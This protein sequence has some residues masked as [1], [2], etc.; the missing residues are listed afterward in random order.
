M[1]PLWALGLFTVARI[2]D[3][4]IKQLRFRDNFVINVSSRA[5][6]LWSWL[7]VLHVF[8]DIRERLKSNAF[9]GRSIPQIHKKGLR[10]LH[11][12]HK[13]IYYWK[14]CN[15]GDKVESGVTRVVVKDWSSALRL[16]GTRH[17]ENV[18]FSK[19]AMLVNFL[20]STSS[21]VIIT[22]EKNCGR[23]A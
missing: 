7:P 15:L 9:S 13:R 19:F 18:S 23:R 5:L 3:G 4:A 10:S 17:W 6:D 12:S 22:L 1:S 21:S 16:C 20:L 8:L 14:W 11:L 2:F